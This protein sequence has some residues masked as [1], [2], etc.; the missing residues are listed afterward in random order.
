MQV[1]VH[2]CEK[3]GRL[4]EDEAEYKSHLRALK[5]SE[6]AEAERKAARAAQEELLK[7]ASEVKTVAELL[8]LVNE[9]S[10]LQAQVERE[11]SPLKYRLVDASTV[12][13]ASTSMQLKVLAIKFD[14]RFGGSS[15]RALELIPGVRMGSGSGTAP[16]S[17]EPKAKSAMNYSVTLEFEKLPGLKATRDAILGA[18]K[19]ERE[20]LQQLQ[21]DAE[22]LLFSESATYRD[23]NEELAQAETSLEALRQ[24]VADLQAQRDG[25]HR[26]MQDAVQAQFQELR[27]QQ[28]QPSLRRA[29]LEALMKVGSI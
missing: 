24:R 20:H 8:A 9:L 25:V 2:K 22:E 15:T 17:D 13:T 6:K 28:Q 10:A 27:A 14:T 18:R 11:S 7:K 29:E 26:K 12:G 23:L 21:V 16:P 5:A 1:T 4:F 19:A 3:T